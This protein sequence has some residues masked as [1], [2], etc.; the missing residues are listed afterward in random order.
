L[1]DVK[2]EVK[3]LEGGFVEY[4]AGSSCDITLFVWEL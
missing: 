1:T 2:I 3:I 4:L